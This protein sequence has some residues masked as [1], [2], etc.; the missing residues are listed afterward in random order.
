MASLESRLDALETQASPD[1]ARVIIYEV[2]GQAPEIPPGDGT[3][4]LLPDNGR[5]DQEA[6]R[7]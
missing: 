4:I 6:N 2:G 1:P 3:F 5:G 7:V